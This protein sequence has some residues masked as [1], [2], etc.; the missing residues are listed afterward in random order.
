MGPL[1]GVGMEQRL[2]I[3]EETG[4]FNSRL[5]I[6][7]TAESACPCVH[8]PLW[9]VGGARVPAAAAQPQTDSWSSACRTTAWPHLRRSSPA[10][11]LHPHRQT[12]VQS[13]FC[14]CVGVGV[15]VCVRGTCLTWL[16]RCLSCRFCSSSVCVWSA[17]CCSSFCLSCRRRCSSSTCADSPPSA[18]DSAIPDPHTNHVTPSDW[19]LLRQGPQKNRDTNGFYFSPLRVSECMD[20][21]ACVSLWQIQY[22]GFHGDQ[23]CASESSFHDNPFPPP[24]IILSAPLPLIS[25]VC[26]WTGQTDARLEHRNADDFASVSFSSPWFCSTVF[27]SV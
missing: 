24:P 7:P 13:R 25:S 20:A 14:S 2:K 22:T 21:F 10:P 1:Q 18:S 9:P 26:S 23:L 5:C 4:Y 19:G 12:G 6:G 27:Y 16:C 17:I 11:E 3:M 15:R 8:Q